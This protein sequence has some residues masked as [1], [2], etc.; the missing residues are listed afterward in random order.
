MDYGQEVLDYLKGITIYKERRKKISDGTVRSVT[1]GYVNRPFHKW[2][3]HSKFTE[4]HPKLWELL[5]KYGEQLDPNHKFSSVTIN[6]N[7][8]CKPHTDVRNEGTTIIVGLC[9]YLEGELVVDGQ[10]IDIKEKPYYFNGYLKTHYNKPWVG[11]RYSLMF[12]SC[13]K[14]WDIKHRDEDIP[15]IR[16]VYHGNQYHKKEIG[17]GI[18]KGDHWLDLGAHIGCFSNKAQRN[19]ATVVAIE[20]DY[21]NYLLLCENVGKENCRNVAVGSSNRIGELVKGSKSYFHKVR[22]DPS[23]SLS[24][25]AF[26]ELVTEGCCVKMDIEGA[27][28]D[29]IDNC[30]FTGIEKMVIAYHTNVDKSLANFHMRVAKLM[31]WFDVVHH[32]E[33]TMDPIDMFPNEIMIYCL[34]RKK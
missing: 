27:E 23:G 20:P 29:I 17:F 11:D 25:I 16:E 12:F 7:V 32:Q 1:L 26:E 6:H 15:I 34:K 19:H 4:Q 8:E 33:I 9:D 10:E 24:I 28:L 5:L 13:R 22:D 30:D 3:G 14:T 21:D 31:E 18:E 2:K